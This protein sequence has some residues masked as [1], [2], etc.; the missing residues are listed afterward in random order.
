MRAT[1]AAIYKTV[2]HLRNNREWAL[3]YLKEFTEEKDD[4]VNVLTY[5]KVVAELSQDGMVKPEWISNSINIAAKVWDIPALRQV[6]PDSIYTN[7][8]LPSAKR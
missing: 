8:F 7:D 1:L 4:K 3:K 2:V 5:E 6:K